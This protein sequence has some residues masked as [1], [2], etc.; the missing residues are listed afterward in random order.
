[1]VDQSVDLGA[2]LRESNADETIAFSGVWGGIRSLLAATLARHVSHILMLLP[3]AADAD[4]VAGDARTFGLTES[5]A[6]PL[7]ASDGRGTSVRDLDFAERLQVLQRLRHRDEETSPP[8]LLTAYIGGAMQMVPTPS[9]LQRSTRELKVGQVVPPEDVRKWLAESGFASTT[10]VQFPGEFAA[11]GGLLD[12]YSPDQPKPLRI[13]WFDDEIESIRQFDLSTQRSDCSLPD[14]SLA[15]IGS[16]GQPS[17]VADSDSIPPSESEL[18]LGSIAEYL[19]PD[20][21][22]V[23]VDPQETQKSAEKLYARLAD[24]TQFNRFEELL[25]SFSTHQVVT[26]TTLSEAGADQAIDLKTST[27]DSFATSLDET[28]QKVDTVAAEHEVLV[29]G[30]TAADG[31]R[32]T[33]LLRDTDAARSGRLH[34]TVADLS[35]GFRLRDLGVLVL[36]GAEL[37]HRSSVR[38]RTTRTRGKPINSALQLEPGDLVVHLSHGVGLYRGIQHIDKNGQHLEHLTL[39]FDGGTKVHV[40]ASRIGLIQRYVGGTKSQPKLAKIGGQAWA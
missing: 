32:L 9:Q 11:R 13:E 4:L 29:V 2:R 20:A 40:P 26:A 24:T 19:P 3:E 16:T 22:V 25:G 14:V 17:M 39:E 38:R 27:A 6:L 1:M 8:V 28:R 18:E 30:D 31:E 36:T 5:Y 33:E 7:S 15:A 23:L 10:A 34:M 35:G 37:F 12:I 21:L